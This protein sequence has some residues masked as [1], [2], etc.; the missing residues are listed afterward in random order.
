MYNL[1]CRKLK[2]IEPTKP[3]SLE[4]RTP[5]IRE[6]PFLEYTSNPFIQDEALIKVGLQVSEVPASQ[7]QV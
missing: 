2:R 4:L 1:S 3:F 7:V 5:E 6:K